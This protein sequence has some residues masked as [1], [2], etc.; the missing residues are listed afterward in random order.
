MSNHTKEC[1]WAQT[2]LSRGGF[3]QLKIACK[4]PYQDLLSGFKNL[5]KLFWWWPC[6]FSF[7]VSL[8][9][10]KL[11]FVLAY[12]SFFFYF[13]DFNVL[14]NPRKIML[15]VKCGWLLAGILC[16][17]LRKRC[18]KGVSAPKWMSCKWGLSYLTWSE[19][20]GYLS[21]ELIQLYCTVDNAACYYHVFAPPKKQ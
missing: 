20:S 4:R 19:F 21:T 10:I 15:I 6:F 2:S 7:S 16:Q 12:P 18:K 5:K 9:P 11:L 17:G 1:G 14:Y 13:R 8:K 3:K